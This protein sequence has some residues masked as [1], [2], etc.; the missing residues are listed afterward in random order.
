M[1]SSSV[2]P[3]VSFV[4][5][6]VS[7]HQWDIHILS[8]NR[9]FRVAADPQGIK[10]LLAE[11]RTLGTCRIVIEATGGYEQKLVAALLEADIPVAVVNP[12]QVRDFAKAFNQLA[13]TDRI[14]ARVLALFGQKV[15][16]RL[17]DK[18]SEKQAELA[19]LVSRRRQLIELRT[20]ETNRQELAT[21]RVV[22]NS[23]K[24]CIATLDQQ[25]K[26][27]DQAIL[28]LIQSDDDWR[29]QAQLLQS[30]PGVGPA[31]CATLIAEL[32]EL[33]RVNRHEISA[34]VG[35][36]PFNHDSG[37]LQGKRAIRGGRTSVRNL[38]YM[39]ALAAKR[40][41][42]IIQAYAQRLQHAGKPFKVVLTACM[43]KLLTILNQ[44]LST[45]TPWKYTLQEQTP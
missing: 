35:L 24:K 10:T 42:P 31:T 23:L 3:V 34:L 18:T 40:C 26:Q 2:S 43:R 17:T 30:V 22:R 45:N 11:L 25:L 44:V 15:G 5:I 29:Q 1:S 14:D 32:P 9:A 4:G 12:R 38:L 21:S 6:D 41:N 13:K 37:K 19:A 16:P 28:K 36:A 20:M 39:A 33:G 7:K 8:Q 27:L